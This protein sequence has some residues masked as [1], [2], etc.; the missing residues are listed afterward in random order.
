MSIPAKEVYSQT[1]TSITY[2]SLTDIAGD[3]LRG[4]PAPL[5]PFSNT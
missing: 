1:K 4:Q 3:H 5:K 2:I